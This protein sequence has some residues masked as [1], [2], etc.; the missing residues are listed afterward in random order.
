MHRKLELE[1]NA[2][3]NR[4]HFEANYYNKTTKDLLTY[5]SRST[6]GLPDELINGGSIKNWGEEFSGSWNQNITKDLAFTLSGNI[7]FQ[8]NKV[9][10]LSKDLPTGFLSRAFQNNGSAESRTIPGY[11][12][13]SFYGYVQEGIYQDAS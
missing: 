13:G 12:I 6:L 4:L 11:P 3:Q 7:T 2:F 9:L 1:L 5:V 8:K 10:S